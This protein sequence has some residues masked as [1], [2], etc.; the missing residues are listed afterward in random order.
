MEDNKNKILQI[1]L[2]KLVKFTNPSIPSG[3]TK[4]EIMFVMTNVLP[5]IKSEPNILELDNPLYV[6]GDIHGQFFDLLR[7]FKLGDL[8]PKSKYL[9]LGDYVDR[10]D[11]SIEVCMLLFGLKIRYPDRIYMI[12]GNHECKNVNAIYGFYDE[13]IKRFDKSIWDTINVVLMNLP[14]CAMISKKVFCVHGGL[15]PDL[16]FLEQIK[17]LPRGTP[18]PESGILCDLLWSDPGTSNQTVE[19]KDSD[20][21]VSYLFNG[22]V[23]ATFMRNNDID[24]ICRAHQVVDSGYKFSFGQRMVTIFSAPN[25]C[26]TYG[27]SASMMKIDEDNVCS[28][29]LLKPVANKKVESLLPLNHMIDK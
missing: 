15:S 8:P 23:T 20:R 25:Y 12:R 6:C 24:L 28:F 26:K 13:C 11:F 22:N 4:E 29:V 18:I 1:I 27:N 5:L 17:K 9:F 16:K 2:Q 10:G 19:W 21:G 3:I 14:I 7:L